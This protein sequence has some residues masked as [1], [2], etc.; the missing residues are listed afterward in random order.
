MK[1]TGAQK[2]IISVYTDE[3]GVD[4]SEKLSKDIYRCV[5]QPDND[6]LLSTLR[7]SCDL[8]NEALFK[9]PSARHAIVKQSMKHVPC[10]TGYLRHWEMLGVS[11]RQHLQSSTKSISSFTLR[12]MTK[13]DRDLLK[14]GPCAIKPPS[15]SN[16]NLEMHLR[17]KALHSVA[18][19]GGSA[20]EPTHGVEFLLE[21]LLN[22]LW[23]SL[24]GCQFTSFASWNEAVVMHL[25][26]SFGRSKFDQYLELES[27]RVIS[28][29]TMPGATIQW[30]HEPA[31]LKA[32]LH[33]FSLDNRLAS[34]VLKLR[35]RE[36]P[37][38]VQSEA[39]PMSVSTRYLYNNMS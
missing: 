25:K 38:V 1:E 21:G 18:P 27:M 36:I 6:G 37:K 12:V 24:R 10:K 17:T 8:A 31:C 14:I 20:D 33:S 5:Q 39:T 29:R 34:H 11:S 15:L 16:I 22:D 4:F 28:E 23:R 35:H 9:L 7:Y 13:V 3:R 30:T 19:L 26:D 2:T 32:S